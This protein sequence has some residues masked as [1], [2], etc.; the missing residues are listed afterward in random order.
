MS[1]SR[2][3][4][5]RGR[6]RAAVR[7]AAAALTLI[8]LTGMGALG[9]TPAQAAVPPAP[10]YAVSLLP[11]A[12]VNNADMSPAGHIAGVAA[13]QVANGALAGQPFVW[14]PSGTL[15][16][17]PL[18][19]GASN[20]WV[21]D[22]NS[23]G[24]VLGTVTASTGRTQGVV[25]KPAGAAYEPVTIPVP[26]GRTN[27]T[28][29]ALDDANRVVGT[30]GVPGT[31]FS[32]PFL[33]T[34]AAGSQDLVAQGYPTDPPVA[35]SPGG[36]VA[37]ATKAY[38][39]GDP[40]SVSPLPALPAPYQLPYTYG[41]ADDGDRFVIGHYPTSRTSDRL[42]RLD[43]ATGVWTS[44]WAFDMPSWRY[45][46][47]DVNAQGDAVG[48]RYGGAEVSW[49]PGDP[50]LSLQSHLAGGYAGVAGDL[51][52]GMSIG[53]AYGISNGRDIAGSA[54]M[55]NN[56]R[57]MR[58]T[59]AAPCTAASCLRVASLTVAATNPSTC[60]GTTRTATATAVVQDQNGTPVP[61]ASVRITLL[62]QNTTAVRTATTSR[63]GQVK[64]S[65]SM[66]TCEGTVTALVD[67]VSKTGA[68]FDRAR[69]VLIRSVIPTI[70]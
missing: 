21:F 48:F 22:V 31:I 5:T 63:T 4:L 62:T 16:T 49:T 15:T 9:A 53:G 32:N 70:R 24:W 41:I 1:R 42:F 65:A 55:G 6:R 59:P 18:P 47:T 46:V 44:L 38:R 45:G 19:A 8:S 35:M 66:G 40:A 50:M 61:N 2:A 25:W 29:V 54:L 39:L 67:S 3:L 51:Y 33:W 56:S 36:W 23:Q 13:S 12:Y 64:V 52:P 28:P 68:E 26:A 69:G 57:F 20:P 11:V 14:Q 37:T 58:M 17:L 60:T 43:A 30:A 10:V 7:S 34:D 27:A